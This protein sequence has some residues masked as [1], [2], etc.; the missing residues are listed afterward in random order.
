MQIG[1]EK[2]TSKTH[3]KGIKGLLCSPRSKYSYTYVLLHSF[4]LFQT[5]SSR[6]FPSSLDN[7]V[8]SHSTTKRKQRFP[9]VWSAPHSCKVPTTCLLHIAY[10]VKQKG[11]KKTNHKCPCRSAG[12]GGF[13]CSLQPLGALCW[14]AGWREGSKECVLEGQE[15]FLKL[16]ITKQEFQVPEFISHIFFFFGDAC[17]LCS[18][19]SAD[20]LSWT[21]HCNY[22]FRWA[23]HL[24]G[25]KE[26]DEWFIT[27][28]TG[29]D[30]L[31]FV[32]FYFLGRYLR[33]RMGLQEK[34]R[35]KHSQ[36]YG[37]T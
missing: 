7:S 14:G 37:I 6:F 22:P 12:A 17:V 36:V 19:F 13:A 21:N 11:G 24:M 3:T 27:H 8:A 23:V 9:C 15:N 2:S 16:G 1:M 4:T 32:V 28:Q 18:I 35:I 25:C 5:M 34:R 29:A 31:L 10:W 20:H 30:F 33:V 26:G